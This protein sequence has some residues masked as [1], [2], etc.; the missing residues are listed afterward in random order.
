MNRGHALPPLAAYIHLPWCLQ[1]CG[2]CD[3]NA[4]AL[5]GALPEAAYVAALRREIRRQAPAARGRALRS[6]FIGGGTPSL[7]SPGAIG[8][9]LEE[10]DRLI[11]IEPG[12][13]VTLEANPGATERERYAAFREAGV[14]RLSLGVQS[15]SDQ[16][17][18]A[19]GRI[20]DAA[21]ARSAIEAAQA[22]GVS[23]VNVDLMYGLPGQTVAE[24]VGDVARVARLGV[25]HVSHYQLTIE[26]GTP[27]GRRPPSGMPNEDTLVAMEEQ[28]RVHLAASGL[29]RY[30]V[31][32]FA[33]AGQ[34]SV[35]N[36]GYWTFGDYL[37]L[38]AGAAGK[39]TDLG[40]AVVRTRQIAA[41]RRWMER[42]GSAEVVQEQEALSDS[43]VRFE[44]FLNALRLCHGVPVEL[45]EARCRM[46]REELLQ[47]LQPITERGLIEER[48][49]WLRPT[50]FGL[51]HLDS[52]LLL[53][54]EQAQSRQTVAA[55]S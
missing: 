2:Y 47:W 48:S 37:G 10:L 39:S 21:A 45:A 30:E 14:N 36:L 52:A 12:A 32:A 43:A 34:R 46:P 38:G 3:F 23:G 40:G 41:P 50:G 26:A 16:H 28:C 8:E 55:P 51:R 15:L 1:R 9:L 13:E 18:G 53:L 19:L 6:V 25:D 33:R 5:R 11:G 20:H 4:H 31:S 7:F 35:H 54:M 24:A 27:F 17:L 44:F 49:G 42:A 29:E 22:A